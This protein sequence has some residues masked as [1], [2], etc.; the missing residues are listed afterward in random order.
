MSGRHS[1]MHARFVDLCVAGGFTCAYAVERLAVRLHRPAADAPSARCRALTRVFRKARLYEPT[2][3]PSIRRAM[4]RPLLQYVGRAHPRPSD[5]SRLLI[6]GVPCV[7]LRGPDPLCVVHGGGF[8]GGDWPGYAGYCAA[9]S[10]ITNR[11]VVFVDY[12]TDRDHATQV[13]QVAS[14]LAAVPFSVAVADSAGAH[15]VLCAYEDHAAAADHTVLFSPVAD[16][17]C[18][19]ASF[20]VNGKCYLANACD[21]SGDPIGEALLHPT[22]TSTLLR[23]VT[24]RVPRSIPPRTTVYASENELFADDARYL[25]RLGA[26]AVLQPR[27]PGGCFHAWPLW[28]IPEATATLRA[29]VGPFHIGSALQKSTKDANMS[30][31][32]AAHSLSGSN[33][34][35]S[36]LSN[37]L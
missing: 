17:T 12:S 6:A 32:L 26:V 19:S 1:L 16:P 36:R 5:V 20:I 31:F 3:V 34:S 11:G 14:V 37:C 29:A 35:R 18:T 28:N 25:E 33:A 13:A 30:G 27:V 7:R 9:M 2:T 4:Q 23:S 22:V 10:A 21:P 24:S 8:V 15:L